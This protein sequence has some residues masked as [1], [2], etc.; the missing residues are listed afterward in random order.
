MISSQFV[1]QSIAEKMQ[2]SRQIGAE[3]DISLSQGISGISLFYSLMHQ[4]FPLDGWDQCAERYLFLAL[5]KWKE[6]KLIQCSLMQGLTGLGFVLRSLPNCSKF[7][8][9]QIQID[10]ILIGEVR[11]IYLNAAPVFLDKDK[12][13]LPNFYNLDEG[14]GGVILYLLS[15]KDN[16]YIWQLAKECLEQLAR[17]LLVKKE[18]N[19]ELIPAW[20]VPLEWIE[21]EYKEPYIKGGFNVSMSS[22][23]TGALIALSYG[24]LEGIKSDFLFE[25]IEQ[26][27]SWISEKYLPVLNTGYWN[28]TLSADGVIPIVPSEFDLLHQTWVGGWPPAIKSLQLAARVLGKSSLLSFSNDLCKILLNNAVLLKRGAT[29]LSIG[30]AGFIG[31]ASFLSSEYKDS[32]LLKM[33]SDFEEAI[34]CAYDPHHPLGFKQGAMDH[35]GNF[36]WQDVPGLLHGSAG[37][38]VA[39][40]LAQKKIEQLSFI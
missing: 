11:R 19:G 25:C 1:C 30:M 13:L 8:K 21:F 10:E 17:V 7:E 39:L 12:L 23:I 38:G 24:T 40:L 6:S 22:G 36:E 37:I 3:L 33:I 32:N 5:E 9:L 35:Y 20:Y 4:A 29:S 15:R 26:I 28:S 18:I 16:P 31:T 2:N 27:S 14:L 34:L